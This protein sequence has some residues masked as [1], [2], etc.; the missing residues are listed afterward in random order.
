MVKGKTRMTFSHRWL[1]RLLDLTLAT[2]GLLLLSPLL[3]VL[4]VAI[5]LEMGGPVL[6]RQKRIGRGK[7]PFVLIKFRTM[8]AAS[9]GDGRPLP[10]GERLTRFGIWLRRTSMDELPQLWNVIK[11][12]ISLVGPRPMPLHY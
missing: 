12:D 11:G 3:L 10:D 9:G 5:G 2:A 6:F 1:K 7:I 4:A 8:R